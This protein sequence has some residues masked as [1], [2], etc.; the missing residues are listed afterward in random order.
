MNTPYF[1]G[2]NEENAMATSP[3]APPNTIHATPNRRVLGDVSTNPRVYSSPA[4]GGLFSKKVMMGSPL[5]RSFTAAVEDGYG[6]KYLKRRRVSG[7]FGFGEV[8]GQRVRRDGDG[9]GAAGVRARSVPEAMAVRNMRVAV[10]Q[11]MLDCG[12]S[13]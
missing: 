11:P 10:A 12:H 3:L 6:L 9:M 4:T 5:K 7:E 1:R 8:V 13:G 2:S